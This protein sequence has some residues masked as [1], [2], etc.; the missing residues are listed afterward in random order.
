MDIIKPEQNGAVVR[1]TNAELA[2]LNSILGTLLHG[3]WGAAEDGLDLRGHFGVDEELAE[4][5]LQDVTQ[6]LASWDEG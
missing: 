2:A 5:L 1:L 3:T 6:V 4:A